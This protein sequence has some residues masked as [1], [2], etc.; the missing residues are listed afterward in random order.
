MSSTSDSVV[1]VEGL[2]FALP[3]GRVLFRD[4]AFGLGRERVGLVGA[5][6]VGKSTLVRILAGELP[7]S[8]GSVVRSGRVAYLPQ[9]RAP[10]VGPRDA[11]A[12]S[13]VA[14]A[15]GIARRLDA[16]A[17]IEAGST[18]P[19]DFDAV[20]S[21]WDVAERAKSELDRLGLSRLALDRTMASLSGGE[22]TRVTLAGLVFDE[23]DLAILDEPTNDLDAASRRAL[24]QWVESWKGGLLV[25]SHDRELLTR[26]ERILELTPGELRSYGGNYAAYETQKRIE[27]EAAARDVAHARKELRKTERDVQ[28]ARERQERR[29]GR[30]HRDRLLGGVP[31]VLLGMRKDRAEGTTGRLADLG[32]KRIAERRERLDEARDHV[33]DRGQLG[34]ALHS[35]CLHA[36]RV[37]IEMRG[38]R[39]THPGA[40]AP[41]L[42]DVTLV[43]RGP[44]RVAVTG[45]NGAGKT[46]LLRL[47][48][49]ELGPDAGLVK[50]GVSSAHVAYLDQRASLLRP[51]ATVLDC[52]RD[53]NP[54]LDLTESRWALARY[55]FAGDAALA[56][57]DAL[58]GGERIRAALACT[59]GASQPPSFLLLDEPTNHLDLN[60]IRAVEGVL[61]EYDG[62]LMV[63]SHDAAFLDAIGVDREFAL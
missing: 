26:M 16:L 37:V 10:V 40:E 34:V 52:F 4:L 49:G 14:K 45:R 3:D 50:L 51:G 27:D 54:E 42:E 38:V 12:P 2:A 17:R 19:A 58:S 9:Q 35:T 7:S 28:S 60:S 20:G 55:L 56:S 57:V 41:T 15:L 11:E 48:M 6:G 13:T 1:T 33:A 61:R 29:S 46:T 47:A 63:V 8:S 18:D 59:V 31:K 22:A 24:Y 21:G 62:A 25:I 44:E 23:P 36:T 30:G 32:D 39:Y 5:N 53:S 43:V